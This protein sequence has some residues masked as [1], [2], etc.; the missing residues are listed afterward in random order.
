MRYNKTEHLFA[1]LLSKFPKLKGS[2]K[3]IYQALNYAFYKKKETFWSTHELL[4]VAIHH[5][6]TF[7]GY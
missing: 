3:L 1:S 6:E 4:E 2:A 7:F 5:Y